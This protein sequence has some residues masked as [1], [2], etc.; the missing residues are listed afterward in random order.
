MLSERCHQSRT[1]ILSGDNRFSANGHH[2]MLGLPT[3]PFTSAET[4]LYPSQ[5]RLIL[6]APCLQDGESFRQMRVGSPEPKN[7]IS[8][9]QILNSYSTGGVIL[10]RF[11]IHIGIRVSGTMRSVLS[12]AL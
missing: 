8:V 5:Q 10:D 11:D 1:F 7:G 12:T 2:A 6:E 9:R 4:I 3:E